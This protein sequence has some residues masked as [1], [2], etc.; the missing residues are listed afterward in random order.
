MQK[1]YFKYW[2]KTDSDHVKFHLLPYHC[3]DVAAVANRWWHNS[4]FLRQVF[5]WQCRVDE[6]KCLAWILFFVS[7]HDL[8]KADLRFQMKSPE[9]SKYLQDDLV[10]GFSSILKPQVRKYDHGTSGYRWFTHEAMDYG[11]DF[12]SVE[13][14]DEWMKRVAGH[15]G[16]LPSSSVCDDPPLV[17]PQFVARDKQARWE[18]VKDLQELFLAPQGLT[19]ADVPENV[20]DFLAGFCSV[21]DWIGSNSDW[22]TMVAEPQDLQE[23]YDTRLLIAEK[24]LA[25]TGILSVLKSPGG[26]ASLFSDYQPRDVQVLVDDFKI[27]QGLTIIEAPTGSGKTEAALAY[28]VKLLDV[29]LADSLIFALPSQATANAMLDRLESV[30]DRV[31]DKGKNVILAH[32]KS[33]F[34]KGFLDLQRVARLHSAQGY[35]EAQVQC[36][37]WLASSRKRV[38][39][40]Q[41][42]V[43]TVDQVLLSVL[44]VRHQFVRSFGVRRSILIVDEVH[45]YDSYMYGLLQEVLKG[46]ARAGGS[47]ILLSATLPA[48]QKES[49]L[50]A[51]GDDPAEQLSDYP[52]VTQS[53]LHEVVQYVLPE[54]QKSP[55]CQVGI[56][57]SPSPLLSFSH[58]LID[59]IISKAEAGAMV[60]VVC[61]L[62][63]DAQELAHRLKNKTEVTVDLFHSRFR[64]RD[65]ME[66]EEKILAHY[67]KNAK[68]HGR[69]LVATQVIEQSL[70][71]DFDW[72]VSQ[73]CPVDLLFQRLG[74]LHRHDN[75]R[76]ACCEERECVVIVPVDDPMDFGDSKWVYQN[77]RALRRTNILLEQH[78]PLV[79]P[80]A[81]R[82]LIEQ[83]YQEEAWQGEP[84]ALTEFFAKYKKEQEG[85][86]YAAS[87]MAHSHSVPLPDTDGNAATLTREGE[88]NIS[89]IP[90]LIR[91]GKRF[92][93]DGSP[94][95][96]LNEF[97]QLEVLNM[98]TIGVAQSWRK[99]LPAVGDD[100][101]CYLAMSGQGNG[102]F[103]NLEGKGNLRYTFERGLEKM[104]EEE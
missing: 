61:N 103:Y 75:K 34:N 77:I 41:V 55:S 47:A 65:R 1:L 87:Y 17:D 95:D 54:E 89:V 74:R 2:A 27:G 52:L 14:A 76:P 72:L 15:H 42:G 94:L 68:R 96:G 35:E 69:I 63:A 73:L 46:Q 9:T 79:F 26:M 102:E 93:L 38:F 22:F 39:L 51:W 19:L 90:V 13:V 3:L 25:A 6:G 59:K 40:G 78:N 70:D 31:F 43:C 12:I 11:C 53:V 64:F 85:S 37:Q 30:A 48:Y 8:G 86:Q 45:A 5:P 24:A 44:P 33:R 50:R 57:L 60:G 28:A 82:E 92:C 21:C 7:L 71:L 91:D 99:V 88:M 10:A 101:I 20:P 100:Q 23:Y 62:V 4:K 84:S 16:S 97:E 56:S 104:E 32:G 98:E 80:R 81:Y 66:R 29:G 67:G 18:L 49:L 58:D 83:V 36:A